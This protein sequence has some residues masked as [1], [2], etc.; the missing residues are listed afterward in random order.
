V[1]PKRWARADEIAKSLGISRALVYPL[2]KRFRVPS[3]SLAEGARCGARLFRVDLF[4]GAIDGLAKE[5]E[6]KAFPH[7]RGHRKIKALR[8]K[9][10]TTTLT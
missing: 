6:G 1:I 5:Q 7:N 3:V 10:K 9:Q 4:L 2:A 8:T